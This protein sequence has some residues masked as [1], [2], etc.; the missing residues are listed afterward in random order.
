MKVL[1]VLKLRGLIAQVPKNPDTAS[2]HYQ[3]T[4]VF[5]DDDLDVSEVAVT[6]R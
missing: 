5:V 6:E 2:A 1:R 3:P 4:L